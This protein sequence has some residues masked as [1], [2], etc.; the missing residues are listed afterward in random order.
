MIGRRFVTRGFVMAVALAI[1][2]NLTATSPA[3]AVYYDS[4][5]TS[6]WFDF[7]FLQQNRRDH[8]AD[9]QGVR[10]EAVGILLFPCIPG[11]GAGDM[12]LVA[13]SME[14]ETDN[15]YDIVQLGLIKCRKTTYCGGDF[16]THA[17]GVPNDNV[18]HFFYTKHDHAEPLGGVVYL[19]DWV[20]PNAP[21]IDGRRYRFTIEQSGSNWLYKVKDLQTGDLDNITRPRT[22]SGG[23]RVWWGSETWFTN[24]S[25]GST[26]SYADMD[27]QT[28]YLKAGTW[29]I[30]YGGSQKD[31]CLTQI[32]TDPEYTGGWPSYWTCYYTTPAGGLSK[33][34]QQF[35]TTN[36]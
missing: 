26:G 28:Q 33:E 14:N 32:P 5:I 36:H 4:C 2:L 34:W 20:T 12:T 27:V 16:G 18:T 17:G 21:E 25:M 19:A 30:T 22:W 35:R 6:N 31:P 15:Y 10:M 7:P 29:Y 24:S 9:F 3:A 1:A 11:S 13:A 23:D 8:V